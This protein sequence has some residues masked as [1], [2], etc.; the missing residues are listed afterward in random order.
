MRFDIL[1]SILFELLEQG[2]VTAP[3]LASKHQVSPR[4]IYRY[5]DRLAPFLPLHV[6]RGR[7]GGIYLADSFRLPAQFL[8]QEE[9][10]RLEQ[11]LVNA[12][13][14]TAQAAL[15]TAKR[16]LSACV[17]TSPAKFRVGEVWLLPEDSRLS[18]K[19][20]ALQ[21]ALQEKRTVR[22]RM[23]DGAEFA[24]EP[25]LLLLQKEWYLVAF[26]LAK[27]SFQALPLSEIQGVLCTEESFRPRSF[28]ADELSKNLSSMAYFS[29][30]S[31]I[32]Y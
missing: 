10:L 15:L 9:Y 30:Q 27:R 21:T 23:A 16:K 20:H 17:R 1:L 13:G 5:V 32:L 8:T 22:L 14:E 19:L 6:L 29:P 12:Y 11:A 2:K 18:A 24:A 7:E 26:V 28:D 31:P 25:H 4:T 3:A